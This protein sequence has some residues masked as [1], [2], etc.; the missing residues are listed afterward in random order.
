MIVVTSVR[1]ACLLRFALRMAA[2]TG[3]RRKEYLTVRLKIK[4]QAQEAIEQA[5]GNLLPNGG[6]GPFGINGDPK[7]EVELD[8]LTGDLQ[9][10][11]QIIPLTVWP[12]S[13]ADE[14]EQDA[15]TV[16]DEVAEWVETEE[17]ARAVRTAKRLSGKE[18][19]RLARELAESADD[20]EQE[21]E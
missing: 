15:W 18:K 19:R 16:Q 10:L 20:E 21:A 8:F 13:F 14:L 1:R 11:N 2:G 6:F 17:A 9:L 5:G 12:G 3:D 4:E 7:A